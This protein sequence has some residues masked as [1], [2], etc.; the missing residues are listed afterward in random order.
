MIPLIL[1]PQIG[2]NYDELFFGRSSSFWLCNGLA[3]LTCGLHV[4]YIIGFS[5]HNALFFLDIDKLYRWYNTLLSNITYTHSFYHPHAKDIGN[6]GCHPFRR[7]LFLNLYK[8]YSFFNFVNWLQIVAMIW[9]GRP[10]K[11]PEINPWLVITKPTPPSPRHFVDV[12][13]QVSTLL[14]KY[15]TII[16]LH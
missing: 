14:K 16:V 2:L 7:P 11:Y 4:S 15:Q 1:A 13:F 3:I 10:A 12:Y 9:Y 5:T 6:T 8:R